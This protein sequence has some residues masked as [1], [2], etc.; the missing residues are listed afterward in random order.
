M[1]GAIFLAFMLFALFSGLYILNKD[2]T[3]RHKMKSVGIPTKIFGPYVFIYDGIF[4]TV[5]NLKG[6]IP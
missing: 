3:A 1:K 5:G 2:E 4:D 6:G